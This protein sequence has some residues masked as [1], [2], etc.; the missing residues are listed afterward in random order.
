MK[1]N[2]EQFAENRRRILDA[3]GALFRAHGFESVTVADVMKAAG[4]THG[5]F[6][7]HFKSKD[8]LI[9]QALS[10]V[11][12]QAD[13]AEADWSNY[14]ASY[15]SPGHRDNLAQGCPVAGLAA[16]AIRQAAEARAVMTAGIR[17]EIE[18]RSRSSPDCTDRETRE[19]AIGSWAAMIGA[20]ILARLVDDPKLSD[21]VLEGTHSWI[22]RKDGK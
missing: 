10:H 3:A 13:T 6:Y 4:L 21:E 9:V 16:E 11:F 14:V 18:L 15:L 19:A 1:V 12:K 8:D 17:H 22:R 2:R 7:G 5:G 20:V